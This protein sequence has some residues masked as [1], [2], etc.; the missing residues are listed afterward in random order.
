MD[1]FPPRSL[2]RWHNQQ[3]E[4]KAM[5]EGLFKI[6]HPQPAE[7]VHLVGCDLDMDAA[8][9]TKVDDPEDYI[10]SV[11]LIDKSGSFTGSLM[12]ARYKQLSRDRLTFSKSI[13]KKYLRECVVRDSAVGSPWIVR[14]N[15]AHRYG[16]PIAPCQE[17][18]ERNN[19]I[20]EQKL[21]KRKRNQ[22]EDA[23][24]AASGSVSANIHTKSNVEAAAAAE[25]SAASI[26]KKAKAERDAQRASTA[27]IKQEAEEE[28]AKK[29][30]LKFPVEDLEVDP[31]TERELKAKIAGEVPRRR[32][33]PP[34]N[35]DISIPAEMF[36]P[37]MITYHFLHAF[38]K[39]LML[40]P[41]SLDDY[42][43]ALEHQTSDLQATLI[44]EIN[45]CLLNLILR[46]VP[47]IKGSVKRG[48]SARVGGAD[49]SPSTGANIDEAADDSSQDEVEEEPE[50][51]EEEQE[52]EEESGDE[53]DSRE[54]TPVK[55]KES[56]EES[57]VDQG[58]EA[59][60][61]G[62]GENGSS[63][64]DETDSASSEILNAALSTSRGWETRTLK[65]DEG[66]NGWELSL[67]GCLAK[68]ASSE[69]MPRLI[70]IL[71]HLTGKDHPEGH[72]NGEFLASQYSS[73]RERYPLLPTVDKLAIIQ[74]LCDLAVM[75]RAIKSFFDECEIRL[76]E[77]RKERVELGRQRKKISEARAAEEKRK[78]GSSEEAEEEA[79]AEEGDAT[80][81]A[82]GD[83]AVEGDAAEQLLATA[84]ASSKAASKAG[85]RLRGS[86]KKLATPVVQDED[87][88]ER[89][90][91]ESSPEPEADE[92][93]EV[94]SEDAGSDDDYSAAPGARRRLGSRQR[95]LLEK[96]AQRK[97]EE[98]ARV[99]ELAR[100]REQQ[101]AKTAENRRLNAERLRWETEEERISAREEEIDREFRRYLM[102]PRLRP[103][104]KDRFHDRYWWF[105]GVGSQTLVSPSGAI[106]YGT[107]RLFVQG[108]S[109]EDWRAA[110]VDRSIKAMFRRREE[111]HGACILSHNEWAVYDK[112]EQV[113]ELVAWLRNKGIR[114][115]HLK[116]Q[117]TMFKGQI[118]PGMQK[119]LE[120][121]NSGT[122]GA[123]GDG[124]A[125][126]EPLVHETRRST[127]K[128]EAA[129]LVTGPH[130]RYLAWTNTQAVK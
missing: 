20:K 27:T 15:L 67:L 10:Y 40:A 21:S 64:A 11:Q 52:E 128:A 113:E 107:G 53:L 78:G 17:T 16:I 77:L 118:G 70:G 7:V 130:N 71:S 57:E 112:P 8:E 101:R 60:V 5:E 83:A 115:N 89:D 29:K 2:V 69:S 26:K 90:E 76:T 123:S 116:R 124:G 94:A 104:G 22:D 117:L 98:A 37:M 91:L 74:C 51:D 59:S 28:K 121:I 85:R 36:E 109:E 6:Q 24:V 61:D 126:V 45:A 99:A 62:D 66:R 34:P 92:E 39:P 119:R 80:A 81:E 4:R 50:D 56:G 35:I 63:N 47:C 102:A 72:I 3:A 87:D 125:G 55:E 79:E 31:V 38:G 13:L 103:L 110:C 105:D 120:D 65:F 42:Q 97:A 25:T 84:L 114:E 129:T 49:D 54:A 82:N 14:H 96:K 41:F 73:P 122:N 86:A 111:E 33:R 46:D 30:P 108:A 68:R 44:T 75:T 9:S 100:Q 32:D 18:I 127:R 48:R 23:S 58:E 43:A 95:A 106:Q 93:E 88:S 12:E 1:V 19:F